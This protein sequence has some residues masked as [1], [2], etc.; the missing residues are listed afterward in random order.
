[1]SIKPKTLI[2][3]DFKGFNNQI[4]ILLED[5]GHTV[6][7]AFTLKEANDAIKTEKYDYILLDLVLPDGD[8]DEIAYQTRFGL[9][10]KIIVL[11][12]DEDMQRREMLFG[13]GILDYISKLNNYEYIAKELTEILLN[14]EKNRGK[15]VLVVDDSSFIRKHICSLLE[16]RNYT[17]KGA[18]HG[19]SALEILESDQAFDLIILD[20]EMPEVDGEKVLREIRKKKELLYLP[21][22]VLS[23]TQDKELVS[24]VLKH[25]ASDFMRKPFSIEELVLKCQTLIEYH[26]SKIKLAKLNESMQEQIKNE[27]RKYQ[28]QERVMLQQSRLASMGEMIGN[29][30]H[31]W[32]QPLNALSL[33]IHKLSLAQEYGKLSPSYL[34]D[35]VEKADSL[36]QRM[37]QT[38]EDF[39]HFFKTDKEKQPFFFHE[40]VNNVMTIL[41]S[42]FKNEG[43]N[44]QIEISQKDQLFGYPSEFQQVLLA[45]LGNA[46][47]AIHSKLGNDG[48][49]V[50]KIY[51]CKAKDAQCLYIEDNGGG[52]PENI[53]PSIFDPYY[54]TKAESGT[55]IGLYMSKRIIEGNM[56]GTLVVENTKS[57]AR[58]TIIIP[59][60]EV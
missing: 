30:A 11:T 27:V 55:G 49:G 5:L 8:G 32:R 45:I 56:G 3:E 44:V 14:L 25:G 36:I 46:R 29:I 2:V 57:G 34:K 4:K 37:S 33:T 48:G 17:P 23:G 26:E 18:I 10:A 40:S 39:R 20:L 28:N 13:H 50:I 7:Q 38:I 52:V 1:M 9:S 35:T 59:K 15:R 12:G 41:D 42:A 54:T 58:F 19:K 43:I 31:Q 6:E 47:D 16:I 24:R 60:V 22:L 21:I 51:D 53:L